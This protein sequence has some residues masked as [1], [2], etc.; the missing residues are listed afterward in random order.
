MKKRVKGIVNEWGT[1]EPFVLAEMLNIKVHFHDLV[2]I[3]GYYLFYKGVKNIVVNR[4]LPRHIQKFVV[5]H[6]IGHSILHPDTNAFL[7]NSF[8][9]RDRQERDADRFAIHLLLTDDMVNTYK[10]RTVDNWASILGLPREIVE[11]RFNA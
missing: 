4:N 3:N 5:A 6:E 11:L 7:S 9:P 1:N 2:G 10:E 8:C